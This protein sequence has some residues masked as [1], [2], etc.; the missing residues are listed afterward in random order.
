MAI[1]INPPDEYIFWSW[2]NDSGDGPTDEWDNR[3]E[4]MTDLQED[5]ESLPGVG[6]WLYKAQYEGEDY[7]KLSEEYIP[8]QPHK[9]K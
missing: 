4:A 9:E 2:V 8:P 3:K 7:K 5:A 6:R 1:W